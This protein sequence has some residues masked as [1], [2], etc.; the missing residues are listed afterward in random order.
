MQ[1]PEDTFK[2][3]L[4]LN[5]CWDVES[6]RYDEEA[7]LFELR[8]RETEKLWIAERCPHDNSDG[9]TCY[10]HV[11]EM[12]WRHLNV[13]SKECEIVSELPRGLCPK[14]GKVYRVRPPWEGRGKHFTMEFEAFAL[15]LIREMPVKK[16]AEI[17]RETDTRLWRIVHGHVDAAYKQLDMKE[18]TCVGVDEMSRRKG[19]NYLTVF[20][21]LLAKRVVFATPGKDAATWNEFREALI[22][23]NGHP[24]SIKHVSMDMSKAYMNGV[25]ETCHNAE[26]VF[27][28]FHVIQNT[29][30]AV[31]KVRRAEFRKGATD[32]RHQLEKSRWLWLKN[33]SNLT[34]DEQVRMERIDHDMLFTAKAYQMRLALQNIYNARK[35]RRASERFASWCRW[36][37]KQAAK[38]K[39]G[40][41]NPMVKI[42]AMIESHLAGILAHWNAH[43]TNAF[44]EGLNSV[45]SAVKRRARGYR[46]VRNIVAVLYFVAGKLPEPKLLFH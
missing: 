8:V 21:D 33:P 27:D 22:A 32:V 7:G 41:L 17:M 23:H 29:N 20:C 31:D 4:G 2:Q 3:L 1:K 36:V 9:V 38:A 37:R 11:K 5:D 28:K 24:Q 6:A 44:M 46:T 45:F 14:C 16:A 43:L 10:D 39:W 13:F 35:V 25:K 30:R 18:V 34:E 26:I 40:L 12:R 42:A 15:T 19:H